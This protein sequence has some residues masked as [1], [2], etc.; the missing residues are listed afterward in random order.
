M[1]EIDSRLL[2]LARGD[3]PPNGAKRVSFLDP[4]SVAPFEIVRNPY[5]ELNANGDGPGLNIISLADVEPEFVEWLWRGR[6]PRGKITLLVGDP[7]SGKSFASLAISAAITHGRP[8][9]DDALAHAAGSVILWNGEDGIEDTIRVRAESCG[10]RLDKMHVIESARDPKGRKMSFGL[11]HVSFIG[12]EI[13][14]RGNVQLVVID[15][16]AALLAG[17]D[18]HRD[19]EVRSA[20]QPLVDLARDH[21]VA[22]LCVLHLRKSEAQRALY[23]VGG[24]I[25]FV[26]LARSVLLAA[27][28]EDSGRRA[29]VPIKQNLAA[30]V[31]PVEYDIG[32]EGEFWWGSAAPDLSAERLLSAAQPSHE[33]TAMRD[34][35]EAILET[36]ADQDHLAADLEA[37]VL[38]A[39]IAKKTFERARA[40]LRDGG[41]I[42]R[43][44]GGKYGPVGWRLKSSLAQ[45]SPSRSHMADERENDSMAERTQEPSRCTFHIGEPGSPCDRCGSPW[46]EHQR[47]APSP[48]DQAESE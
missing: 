48:G 20:L 39:G 21:D 17:V 37:A 19:A 36:L 13:R 9:P 23:R 42:E 41:Q 30:P 32:P 10:V 33:R 29:I 2:D 11:G 45:D 44:G 35:Q 25:G 4:P 1:T 24:S 7:G 16:I 31:D 18:S 8:L 38:E 27:R 12:D 40:A 15:P 28:D 22:V 46:A 47:N 26:G 6:V 3:K 43:F 14:K 34:A 5:R